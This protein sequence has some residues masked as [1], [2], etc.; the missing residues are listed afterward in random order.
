MGWLV[1]GWWPEDAQGPAVAAVAAVAG[2]SAP[3]SPA[4]A[5]PGACLSASG[6]SSPLSRSSCSPSSSSSLLLLVSYL[7]SF[8]EVEDHAN[9]TVSVYYQENDF[10]SPEHTTGSQ[11]AVG[12][13]VGTRGVIA[14]PA[15]SRPP[16]FYW[17]KSVPPGLGHTS[18]FPLG[19]NLNSQAGKKKQAR[20]KG[21][22]KAL[23]TFYTLVLEP[24]E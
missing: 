9:H 17:E 11:P 15:P 22:E 19:R 14:L 3:A 1:P 13:Q 6:A 12:T 8:S 20:Q 2:A 5:E 10:L 4:S 21:R 23:A 18:V 7:T 24:H 16:P